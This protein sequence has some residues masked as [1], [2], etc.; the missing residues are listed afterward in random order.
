[1]T[2]CSVVTQPVGNNDEG[3][4]NVVLCRDETWDKEWLTF[5]ADSRTA[6]KRHSGKCSKSLTAVK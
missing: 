1:M 2:Y 6:G 3:W 5:K 4:I